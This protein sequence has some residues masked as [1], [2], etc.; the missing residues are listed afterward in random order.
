MKF[1]VKLLDTEPEIKKKIL[2]AL[3]EDIEVTLNKAIP[4]INLDLQNI[5]R[6][7]IQN[8]PEYQSLISGQLRL[9][10]GI[11]DPNL[12]INNI[13]NQWIN[14]TSITKKPFTINGRGLSMGFSIGM[15]A[16]DYADV[17]SLTEASVID[18]KGYSLP[19]LDWLLLQGGKII[20]RDYSVELGPFSTS[21][22]GGAIMKASNTNWRVPPEFAGTITNNWVTRAID[23]IESDIFNIIQKNIEA[24]I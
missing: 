2:N 20:V 18:I 23:S 14:N 11:P 22:S 15:V 4:N 9:E 17:L 16:S 13:I 8:Q 24:N 7:S 6:Q 3:R 21:R 12:R 1:S 19:W 10:F 5:L